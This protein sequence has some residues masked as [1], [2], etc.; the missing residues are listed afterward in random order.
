M[1]Q[2]ANSNDVP[3]IKFQFRLPASLR[4][5]AAKA[6]QDQDIG[7]MT[8]FLLSAL[9]GLVLQNRRKDKIEFPLEFVSDKSSDKI[10]K[11]GRGG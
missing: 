3:D 2:T 4:R 11:G 5:E 9:N 10:P 7:T 8:D 6:L 1:K